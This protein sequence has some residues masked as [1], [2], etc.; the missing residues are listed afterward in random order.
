MS[1][2]SISVVAGP[3]VNT[4]SVIATGSVQH[5]ITDAE[6]SS[7]KINDSEL[8][9]AVAKYF[10]KA[11]NDAYLHSPT[12]WDDLYKR[13]N[14]PQVQTVMVVDSARIT[15]ITSN[16]EVIASNK[17]SNKSSV[18]GTFNAGVSTQISNTESTTWTET[19]SLSISESLNWKVSFEGLG[20]AG[21]SVT[22]GFTQT[23]AKAETQSQTVTVGSTEGISVTLQPGQSVSA[24][25]NTT[26]GT[27]NIRIVYRAYL[28]GVTAI[29][30]N[31]TY[32]DHHFW[33]LPISN[34]MSAAGIPNSIMVTQDVQIGYYSNASV[35]LSD[36]DGKQVHGIRAVAAAS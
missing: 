30:Y 5:I 18:P 35:T 10:G 12:P 29:N 9:Q 4:S 17:F 3:D 25:L 34:V 23:F 2:I 28:T 24:N 1:G 33:A 15:G 21:G 16:P 27:M 11:P 32:K 31:P 7:F 36:S 8:K 20:E 6:V 13:Y 14:W 19:T 22:W 26:R